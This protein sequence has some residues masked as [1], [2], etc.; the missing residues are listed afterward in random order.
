[1]HKQVPETFCFSEIFAESVRILP[2]FTEITQ[3]L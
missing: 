3:N 2:M 1:M